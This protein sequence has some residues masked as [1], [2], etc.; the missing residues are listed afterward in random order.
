MNYEI[1]LY[2]LIALISMLK[3]LTISFAIL[4]NYVENLLKIN[5]LMK[6]MS[7][8]SGSYFKT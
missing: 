7:Y 4:V 1:Q 6:K 3:R 8:H 5:A 2:Y